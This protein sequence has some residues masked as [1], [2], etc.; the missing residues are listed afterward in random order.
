MSWGGEATGVGVHR[1]RD[2]GAT[3]EEI[4]GNLPC[5]GPLILRFNPDRGE[6]WAGGP[7]LFKLKQ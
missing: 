4:T 6:L 7:A 3:W 2:G 5:R 1:T